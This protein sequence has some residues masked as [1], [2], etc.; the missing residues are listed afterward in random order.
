MLRIQRQ[1]KSVA[2]SDYLG[3]R[4]ALKP[5]KSKKKSEKTVDTHGCV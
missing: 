3:Q 1:A 4:N 5:E 2:V